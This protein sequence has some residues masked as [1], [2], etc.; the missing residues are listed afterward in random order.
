VA[1]ELILQDGEIV[2]VVGPDCFTLGEQRAR[3]AER[4]RIVW[5]LK[6]GLPLR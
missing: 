3:H 2:G 6:R 1:W 4:D 5:R